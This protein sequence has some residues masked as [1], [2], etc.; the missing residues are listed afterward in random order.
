MVQ[1]FLW[2]AEEFI[3]LKQQKEY[4]RLK[5]TGKEEDKAELK[6]AYRE[7]EAVSRR[8]AT[9][10]QRDAGIL[11]ITG[12]IVGEYGDYQEEQRLYEQALELDRQY[13]EAYW[14][15]GYSMSVELYEGLQDDD[16]S[17]VKYNDLKLEE[18][19]RVT[20]I[21]SNYV[22]AAELDPAQ[23]WIEFDLA[24]ELI[25]WG[26]EREKSIRRLQHSAHLNPAVRFYIKRELY[27]QSV[28]NNPKVKRLLDE[29]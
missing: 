9:G 4:K 29:E 22:K 12:L 10:E 18:K 5:D 2:L 13:A 15:L 11:A 25:H 27:L 19:K 21:C 24:C 26:I 20:K 3:A 7:A 14:Y 28:L 1:M 8:L 6:K 17:D 16:R 23:A